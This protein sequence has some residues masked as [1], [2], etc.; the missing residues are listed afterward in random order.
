MAII[1]VDVVSTITTFI[2][3]SLRLGYSSVPICLV[4]LNRLSTYHIPDISVET[5][6]SADK[7]IWRTDPSLELLKHITILC[8]LKTTIAITTTLKTHTSYFLRSSFVSR[9]TRVDTRAIINYFFFKQR[10][11]L[12]RSPRHRSVAPQAVPVWSIFRKHLRK[13][14]CRERPTST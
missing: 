3:L 2:Q 12:Q 10:P 14:N 11:P 9:T 8:S 7:Y 13:R 5:H 6:M 1:F 4:G